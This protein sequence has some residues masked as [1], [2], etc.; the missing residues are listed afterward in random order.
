VSMAA[1]I[2][3]VVLAGLCAVVLIPQTALA[4]EREDRTSAPPPPVGECIESSGGDTQ[5]FLDCLRAKADEYGLPGG[6]EERLRLF[7]ESHPD[8]QARL[9]LLADRW[10]DRFDRREDRRDRREDYRDRWEDR[11]D[12]DRDWEDL[13]DRREDRRDRREDRWD[14]WEDRLDRRKGV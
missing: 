4:A 9:R 3:G 14:K 1:S 12:Q 10:E 2:K 7:L 8:W 11:R 6:W 5:A 13:F